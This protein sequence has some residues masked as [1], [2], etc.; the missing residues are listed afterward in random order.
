MAGKGGGGAW[1]V[2]YADFV[3]A[4]M[5]FFMVMWITAQNKA[6]KESIAQYFQNPLGTV[7]EPWAT[8]VHGI[9][10]ASAPTEFEGQQAGPNG[11]DMPGVGDVVPGAEGDVA[12]GLPLTLRIFERLDRTRDVGTLVLFAD[13]SAELDDEARQ[14]LRALAPQ[15]IGKPNKIELRGHADL[16]AAAERPDG[17][18]WALCLARCQTVMKFLIDLGIEKERIRLSQDGTHEPYSK[19]ERLRFRRLNSRVEVFAVSEFS[20]DHKKTVDDRA[21][22]FVEAG[23]APANPHDHAPQPAAKALD[24]GGGH[25]GG[26]GSSHGHEKAAD[27]GHG[28]SVPAHATGHESKAAPVKHAAETKK[29][30]GHGAKSH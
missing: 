1:K 15:L 11:T 14:Q 17:D 19:D 20:H 2:A 7:K 6:V 23:K 8:S 29:P 12:N 18:V 26:H 3:T 9:E 27:T 10:G 16:F 5:A 13:W 22:D 28:K 30:S 25:G 4:M 21:G 24:H